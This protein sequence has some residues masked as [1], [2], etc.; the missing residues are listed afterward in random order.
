MASQFDKPHQTGIVIE[1]PGRGLVNMDAMR[2]DKAV[3]E[4]DE[5]LYFDY[6]QKQGH[7]VIWSKMPHGQ[8]PYPICGFKS[9]PSVEECLKFLYEN[10]SRRHGANE[11]WQQHMREAELERKRLAAEMDDPNEASAEAFEYIARKIKN[12]TRYSKSHS[13]TY[14]SK[15]KR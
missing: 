1:V 11:L 7:W 10:D 12:T 15:K 3:N 9:V 6:D 14:E 8:P 5:R 2:V 13:K 4:Y